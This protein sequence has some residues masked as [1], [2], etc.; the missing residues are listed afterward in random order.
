[1]LIAAADVYKKMFNTILRTYREKHMTFY[2]EKRFV[3]RCAAR[4][5]HTHK[6]VATQTPKNVNQ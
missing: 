1:M 2:S 5:D 6:P 3:A 4:L